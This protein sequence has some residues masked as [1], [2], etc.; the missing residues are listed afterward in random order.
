[1]VVE[2]LRQDWER[3]VEEITSNDE[4]WEMDH[5]IAGLARAED[6]SLIVERTKIYAGKCN[7]L[8]SYVGR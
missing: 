2:E 8:L 6:D 7:S 3:A 4:T 1:M 5:H